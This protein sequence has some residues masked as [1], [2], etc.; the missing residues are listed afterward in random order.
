MNAF[1]IMKRK[2][3]DSFSFFSKKCYREQQN[4]FAKRIWEEKEDQSALCRAKVFSQKRLIS[5]CSVLPL[6]GEKYQTY[7]FH[8]LTLTFAPI[9][10]LKNLH[11]VEKVEFIL[12]EAYQKNGKTIRKI[13]RKMN[14]KIFIRNFLHTLEKVLENQNSL[15]D[16]K[17]VATWYFISFLRLLIR[18]IWIIKFN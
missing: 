9:T 1:Q 8:F 13:S 17:Q 16:W 11:V 3:N 7:L 6:H 4:T 14:K 12:Y 2:H 15:W 18:R 5:Y 10:L